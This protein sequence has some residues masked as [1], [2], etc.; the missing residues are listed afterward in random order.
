MLLRALVLSVA[1]R[2]EELCSTAGSLVQ[3]RY[4][5]LLVDDFEI[6]GETGLLRTKLV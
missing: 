4:F 6:M 2:P 5:M 1:I 3:F